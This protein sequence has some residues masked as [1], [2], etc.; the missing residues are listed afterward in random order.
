MIIRQYRDRASLRRALQA[1]VGG[2]SAAVCLAV[3]VGPGHAYEPHR[4]DPQPR[5]INGSNASISSFPWQV[6]LLDAGAGRSD[7][8][9]YFCSGSRIAPDL[10]IT[11][12]HCLADFTGKRLARL[13]VISGRTVINDRS[14]GVSSRV[15][16]I[17]LPR[18]S[19]GK[20][21]YREK[22]GSAAWDVALLKL[23][24]A[25]QGP[26]VRLAGGDEAGATRP[27]A[28]AETAGWGVTG[29]L[30]PLGAKRLRKTGQVILPDSVCRR[31][32]GTLFRPKLMIC[33]GGSMGRTSACAGDSGGPLLSRTSNGR[34]LVGITSFGDL[35]CRGNIPSVDTRVSSDPIRKWVKITAIAESGIDPVGTGGTPE[36]RSRWCQVPRLRNLSVPTARRLLRSRGCRVGKVKTVRRKGGKVRRVVRAYLPVG[37]FTPIGHRINLRVT[38]R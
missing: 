26:V 18:D 32:I 4:P 36:P 29:P 10:V 9:R 37:W 6:A 34:R 35:M 12:A 21:K 5:I 14:S 17:L 28:R 25:V 2:I 27:G 31:D 7:R 20:P 22:N 33:F 1:V 15:E 11:A 30:A 38:R 16:R 19:Q 8:Q 24:A 3:V 23:N 13:R